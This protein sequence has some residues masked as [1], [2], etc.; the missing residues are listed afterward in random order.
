MKR[1]LLYTKTYTM[2]DD[3]YSEGRLWSKLYSM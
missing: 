3:F 2:G 1:G